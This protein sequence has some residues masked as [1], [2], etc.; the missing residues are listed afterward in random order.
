MEEL[1]RMKSEHEK[2]G[3][4]KAQ[5]RGC[6]SAKWEKSKTLYYQEIIPLLFTFTFFV[7]Y[8]YKPSDV[9][10]E[11]IPRLQTTWLRNEFSLAS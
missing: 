5:G 1:A 9:T 7:Q 8:Q 2:Y 3:T 10:W 11:T 6:S 4:G